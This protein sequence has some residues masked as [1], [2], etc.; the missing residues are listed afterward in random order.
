VVLSQGPVIYDSPTGNPLR[1]PKLVDDTGDTPHW[2]GENEQID[3]EEPTFDEFKLLP[4]NLKSIKV[5]HR[6]S[7]ELARHAVVSISST[8]QQAL[9]RR[10]ASKMDAAFLVGSTGTLDGNGNREVIGLWNQPGTQT[11]PWDDT[12]GGKVTDSVIDAVGKLVTAEITDLSRCVWYMNTAAYLKALKVKDADGR[13]FLVPDITQPG[14]YTLSGI[15]VVPTSKLP[16]G[17]QMLVDM[18]MVAVGRD[19]APSVKLLDQTFGDYDQLAIRVVARM[20]IG[21]LHEQGVVKIT[22]A[23][24]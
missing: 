23:T 15:K 17:G 22:D 11:S 18:S 4:E 20:D 6:F 8:M 13:G 5:L 24:P 21:L 2:H 16:A 9:V 14:N 10:V 3:E 7:N 12:T 19:L 1:I